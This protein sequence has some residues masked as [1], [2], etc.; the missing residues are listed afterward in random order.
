MIPLPSPT[1]SRPASQFFAAFPRSS[2]DRAPRLT[3]GASFPSPW[4]LF[5]FSPSSQKRE[6]TSDR[7]APR[8]LHRRKITQHNC[9]QP[10]H[11][12]DGD[13]PGE[14]RVFFSCGVVDVRAH[15]HLF[16]FFIACQYTADIS[17]WSPNSLFMSYQNVSCLRF[18]P[19][20][21]ERRR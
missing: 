2:S 12:V 7:A 9:P 20:R 14:R 18:L 10:G 4:L 19:P 16:F 8:V 5:V 3:S 17:Y 11:R 13:N 6:G 21:S 15:P 1:P